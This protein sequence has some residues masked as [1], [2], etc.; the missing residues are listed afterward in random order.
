MNWRQQPL[1][2]AQFWVVD[3]GVTG[4]DL[5]HDRLT[6]LAVA[7]VSRYRWAVNGCRWLPLN[8]CPLGVGLH[9]G[10]DRAVDQWLDAAWSPTA[11][12]PTVL[13]TF[14]WAF[15][16]RCVG[17][18]WPQPPP[19]VDLARIL[20]PRLSESRHPDFNT[21]MQ[22]VGVVRHG[23]PHDPMGDVYA[24]TE[25][26]LWLL[27]YGETNGITTLDQLLNLHSAADW[28]TEHRQQGRRPRE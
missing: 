9:R 19:V 24:M 25:S 28:L 7:P 5:H 14:N 16:A 20:T 17:R 27:A 3:V 23:E 2:R 8:C 11:E 18:L 10:D 6:G 22:T 21:A 12:I 15:V 26:L 13:V 1:L 4:L